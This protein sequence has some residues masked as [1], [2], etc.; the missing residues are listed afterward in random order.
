MSIFGIPYTT[1]K[2]WF[3]GANITNLQQIVSVFELY[4]KLLWDDA[5]VRDR[6]RPFFAG[7]TICKVDEFDQ[8]SVVRKNT[9]VLCHLADLAMV[10]FHGIGRINK[11]PDGLRILEELA[12]SVPVVTPW[13]DDYWTIFSCSI[14]R[15]NVSVRVIADSYF[16]KSP[17]QHRAQFQS[18][19]AS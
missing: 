3:I 17:V 15:K 19:K 12:Q 11:L 5:P 8:G 9:L 10:V 2:L 14:K 13:L 7:I 16:R 1:F 6:H 18:K 4:R